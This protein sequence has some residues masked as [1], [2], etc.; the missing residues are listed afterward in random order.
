VRKINIPPKDLRT[1]RHKIPLLIFKPLKGKEIQANKLIK[2]K[3]R[4]ERESR[5]EFPPQELFSFERSLSPSLKG[6][7]T[8][9]AP[10]KLGPFRDCA[11]LKIFRSHKVTKATLKRM[12][13]KKIKLL[14]IFRYYINYYI[15]PKI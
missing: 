6:C 15:K 1:K 3:K 9:T 7:K 5:R 8:P 13:I 11:Y 12:E 10:T 2:K 4:G 14:I